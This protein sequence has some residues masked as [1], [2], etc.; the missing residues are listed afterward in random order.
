MNRLEPGILVRYGTYRA[1]ATEETPHFPINSHTMHK[2][3]QSE[4]YLVANKNSDQKLLSLPRTTIQIDRERDKE[5][6]SQ[7]SVHKVR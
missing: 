7:V 1:H 5:G 6:I 4:N 2:R 3:L